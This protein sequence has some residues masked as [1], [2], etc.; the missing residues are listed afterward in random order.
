[1]ILHDKPKKKKKKKKKKNTICVPIFCTSL[2]RNEKKLKLS[3]VDKVSSM[4][5]SY[6]QLHEVKPSLKRDIE[7][8]NSRFT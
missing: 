4:E 6:G 3:K 8:Q 1:M 5:F 2:N 7:Y